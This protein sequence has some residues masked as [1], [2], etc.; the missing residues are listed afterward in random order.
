MEVRIKGGREADSEIFMSKH[1][2]ASWKGLA[3]GEKHPDRGSCREEE[4]ALNSSHC[5]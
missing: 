1:P 4:M 3:W 2:E 5:F